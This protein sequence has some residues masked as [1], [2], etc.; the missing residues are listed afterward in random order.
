MGRDSRDNIS[1][2]QSPLRLSE[3][4]PIGNPDDDPEKA[5][6]PPTTS[7]TTNL[8]SLVVPNIASIGLRTVLG[9]TV[10]LYILNQKH[11][12]P[13]PLSSIVS[14]TLFWPTLPI[15]IS[16]RIGKWT[17]QIDETVVIGGAPFGFLKYPDKLYRDYGVRLL[18]SKRSFRSALL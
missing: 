1:S 6:S 16:R 11:A 8:T 13:R 18:E 7:W 17:T 9:L 12:L 5:K 15:T 3:P 2:Q 4:T 14:K 10:A